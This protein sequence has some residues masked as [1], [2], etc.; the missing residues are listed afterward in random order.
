MDIKLAKS[1]VIPS[2]TYS[3][4][5]EDIFHDSSR[6]FLGTGPKQAAL[7][8]LGASD[9]DALELFGFDLTEKSGSKGFYIA[10]LLTI[11]NI[12]FHSFPTLRNDGRN[13]LYEGI[14]NN[15]KCAFP[16]D[17][18]LNTDLT[19]LEPDDN[20]DSYLLSVVEC[21]QNA[22]HNFFSIKIGLPN[23]IITRSPYS[24]KKSKH[25]YHLTLVGYVFDNINE[26]KIFV[27][28]LDAASLGI[29]LSIYRVGCLRLM[30]STKKGQQRPLLPYEL[31]NSEGNRS[32]MPCDFPSPFDYFKA[33]TVLHNNDAYV[34]VT[35][36]GQLR[37]KHTGGPAPIVSGTL[38][39]RD[40]VEQSGPLAVY[41]EVPF[42]LLETAI[43][44]LSTNRAEQRDDWC[45][46]I[47]AIFIVSH[48]NS[49]LEN[50]QNLAHRFSQQSAKYEHAAVE[51]LWHTANLK[52]FNWPSIRNWL[53]GDNRELW[54]TLRKDNEYKRF[55]STDMSSTYR[56]QYLPQVEQYRDVVTDVVEYH[57]PAVTPFDLEANHCVIEHA[58]MGTSK[59]ARYI[60]LIL[61]GKYRSVLLLVNRQTL[62]RAAIHRLNYAIRQ[63]MGVYNPHQL[64]RDYRRPEEVRDPFEIPDDDLDEAFALT[65]PDTSVFL[66]DT[67]DEEDKEEE[68]EGEGGEEEEGEEEEGVDDDDHD[69]PVSS[70]Q[71][72]D[73]LMSA[74]RL[75]VQ[76]ESCHK[77]AGRKF[78]LVIAD[79]CESDIY[80]F[81][82]STMKRLKDS[83]SAFFHLLKDAGK[84]LFLDAFPSDRQFLLL[85]HLDFPKGTHIC[86]R[87][88]SWKPTGRTAVEIEAPSSQSKKKLMFDA[89]RHKLKV[90]KRVVL[91]TTSL[92]CGKQLVKFIMKEF[93]DDKK[94]AFYNKFTDNMVRDRHFD[95]VDK[96]WLDVDIL[97]YTPVLLAGVSF[98]IKNHF[99]CLFVWAY[100]ESSHVR[101]ML[102]AAGRVRHFEIETMFY[103]LD[104]QNAHSKRSLPLTLD[105]VKA[106]V[107]AQG[108]LIKRYNEHTTQD[109]PVTH[110]NP[111]GALL[112]T[113]DVCPDMDGPDFTPEHQER[114]MESMRKLY[115]ARKMENAPAWL[116]DIH[117]RNKW[118]EY[119]THNPRSFQTVFEDYLKL[120]G[121]EREGCL[122]EQDVINWENSMRTE[123]GRRRRPKSRLPPLEISR[124]YSDIPI[125]KALE[126]EN[127]RRRQAR[128]TSNQVENLAMERYWFDNFIAVR[129]GTEEAQEAVF[130]EM[131]DDS[132]KKQIM[133]NLFYEENCTGDELALRTLDRNPFAETTDTLPTILKLLKQLCSELGL[134][135]THD[136][137]G[138]FTSTLL[139][140]KLTVLQ[141]IVKDLVD[142]MHLPASK[143]KDVVK[144]CSANIDI[145]FK[146]FSGTCL[147]SEC[148]R[149]RANN[150]VRNYVY[151]INCM[152]KLSE[153]LR[154]VIELCSPVV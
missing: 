118:E 15:Q 127:C 19:G 59:T 144:N 131:V 75:V 67:S 148:S 117:V 22:F 111:L 10:S 145:V 87:H 20:C 125:L 53:R 17:L 120:A 45:Y 140:E 3:G 150:R 6:T 4:R 44:S 95:D 91:F 27:K 143:S 25:S 1:P 136:F 153:F 39:P 71:I 13:I 38:R 135:S 33:T 77:I 82:S 122:T 47:W 36:P 152:E 7:N 57:A 108:C 99:H 116:L 54:N 58:A 51:K 154:N 113:L 130:D 133:I 126:Y 109:M 137:E 121:W 64:F 37:I 49:Y 66:V 43:L 92:A 21:I 147:K 68:G 23:W 100:S 78:D 103:A 26:I 115:Y 42:A 74:K 24:F 73:Y 88:N 46:T 16:I 65:I 94:I 63:H 18:D 142:I 151:R 11:F 14:E 52:G 124:K 102:Q 90:G 31:T 110:I 106:S 138:S 97:I 128:G 149:S 50:G 72:K 134:R 8:Y 9:D 89:I 35:I 96:W 81:S 101:D 123:V 83:S 34:P 84:L 80:Q 132:R 93:E 139:E 98:N 107:D 141:P 56:K 32:L 2:K 105:A 28:E 112:G 40:F 30:G 76:M 79:E 60:E 12:I 5:M 86:Y 69:E 129:L 29:D 119:L 70:P 61:S 114:I 104:F 48:H 41:V 55:M 146:R 85:K 62:C